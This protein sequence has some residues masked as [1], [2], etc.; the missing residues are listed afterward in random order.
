M[1]KSQASRTNIVDQSNHILESESRPLDL[2][3]NAGAAG[4]SITRNYF[5]EERN[6]VM[7]G[8]LKDQGKDKL[9]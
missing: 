1:E 4:E 6:T 3:A 2:S 5:E 7:A 8:D 9:I